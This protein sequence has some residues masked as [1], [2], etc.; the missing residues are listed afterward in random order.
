MDAVNEKLTS[1]T[2]DKY[3]GGSISHWEMESISC[4][5]H[6]H[7]LNEVDYLDYGLEEYSDLSETPEIDR[8][9]PIKGKMIPIFKL[10]RIAGT[11]LDRDKS[12]KTVTLLTRSGVV[13]VKIFG[14]AFSNYDK[15]LS[16][17]G[18]DGHKHVIRTSEFAR[19][20]KIIVTRIR[21][22][23]TEY[24]AKKYSKTPWHLVETIKEI[25]DGQLIIDNRNDEE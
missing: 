13:T 12:K 6:E 2:W 22:G 21:D 3:C 23:E 10:H 14:G 8:Y 7:E 17:K 19:G 9:I 4:Y 18:A 16:E 5:L 24:R 11:V 25:V 1:D 20:N 15:Q